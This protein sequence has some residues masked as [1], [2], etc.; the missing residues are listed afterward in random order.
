LPGENTRRDVAAQ[1]R[2]FGRVLREQKWLVALCIIVAGFAAAAY[3]SSQQKIYESTAKLLL[4]TGDLGAAVVGTG[5]GASDPQRQAATDTQLVSL[6][7]VGARVAKRLH[8]PLAPATV[9]TSQSGDSNIISVDVRDPN[10]K[11]A[12]AIANA[13]SSEFIRFRSE[14]NKRRYLAALQTLEARLR[15]L[16]KHKSSAE[17]TRLRQQAKDVRLLSSLQTGDAQVIQKA[18]PAGAAVSP[19]PTRDLVLGLII[20]ALVGIALAFL[21]DRLDRRVKNQAQAEEV[22][23][24]VPVIGWIPKARRARA[25]KLRAAD[26]FYALRTNL[27]YLSP[28]GPFRS[29]LV[30]SAMAGEGKSSIALNLGL[31]MSELDGRVLLLDADLRRPA[32]SRRL[33]LDNRVGVSRVLAGDE[34]LRGSVQRTSVDAASLNGSGPVPTI[35]GDL[36][37]VPSGPLPPS[38]QLLLTDHALGSLLTSADA[39][40]DVVIVDGPPIGAVADMLP[41]ARGVD[42]VIVVVRLYHSRTDALERLAAQLSNAKVKPVGIVLLGT[43]AKSRGYYDYAPDR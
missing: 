25:S 37:I 19:K 6:P 5:V 1:L 39:E 17:R 8:E 35:E 12:A 7:A 11:R 18:L 9:S 29:L 20:G 33:N 42:A 15:Q 30:T 36:A 26:A 24:G 23:P 22:F 40:S 4:Q 16:P 34:E 2:E 3:S 27:G 14:A 31:A 13:F 28:N 32:L 41:V 21:R 10:P 38:P 43:A